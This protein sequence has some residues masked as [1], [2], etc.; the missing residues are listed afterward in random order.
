[1]GK[2]FCVL[3]LLLA[4][5][6]SIYAKQ[7]TASEALQ[8]AQQHVMKS[9]SFRGTTS[10]PAMKLAYTEIDSSSQAKNE[11]FYIYNKSDSSGYVIVSGD[12]RANTI[13]GFA[14]SGNFNYKK[15]SDGLRYWLGRF[16]KQ[17]KRIVNRSASNALKSTS[18]SSQSTA[19]KSS[20]SA[21]NSVVVSPFVTALWDQGSPYNELCPTVRGQY[22]YTGCVATAMAEVMY[23]FQYP[24][25]GTGSNSYT[26]VTHRF[27]LS[28][29]FAKTTFDW[30]DMTASYGS[31]STS[32]QE[33]AV[34]TL[35]YDCGVSCDM[36][37]G[38]D[39]D[40]G[41][42]AYSQDMARAMVK[43]F[44]YNSNLQIYERDFYTY[45]EWLNMVKTEL[46]N[47]RPVLYDGESSEG[48]HQFVCDGYNS[49]DYFHFNWG[50]SGEDNGYFLLTA[51]NPGDPSDYSDGFN[52]YDEI[53]TGL[54]KTTTGSAFYPICS[55]DPPVSSATTVTPRTGTFTVSRNEVCN[56][57]I[58]DFSGNIGIALYTNSSS[59]SLVSLV[60]SKSLSLQSFSN[61]NYSN[62]GYYPTNVSFSNTSIPSSVANGTYRMYFVY[63]P[64]S[65]TG[66]TIMRGKVGNVNY[67]NVTVSSDSVKISTPSDSV[68][69]LVLNSLTVNGTLYQDRSGQFALNIT[70]SGTAEYL[71]KIGVKLTSTT[72]SKTYELMTQDAD[73]VAG[74][75]SIYYI[76]DTITLAPGIYT[77]TAMYDPENNYLSDS[78]LT[79]FGS[80]QTVTVECTLPVTPAVTITASSSSICTG[81]SVTFT[82]SESNGGTS[83]SYQWQV[84]GVDVGSNSNSFTTA[85]LSNNAVVT[86]IL[87][88]NLSCA[89]VSTVTSNSITM[90]VSTPTTPTIAISTETTYICSG[91]SVTFSSATTNGGTSPTFQWQ[92]NSTNESGG[93]STFTTTALKNGDQVDCV[94][95]T[96]TACHNTATSN[97]ITMTVAT[98]SVSI[99][100]PTAVMYAGT[101]TVS[102]DSDYTYSIDGTNYQSSN[103]FSDLPIGTYSVTLKDVYGTVSSATSAVISYSGNSGML[104]YPNPTSGTVYLG[105]PGEETDIVVEIVSLT[106]EIKYMQQFAVDQTSRLVSV[107]CSGMESG[108]YIIK[109]D[110]KK[111]HSRVKL[112]KQ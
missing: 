77:L 49:G 108:L 18:S 38:V 76:N 4:F 13:L 106:G 51:L 87:T 37:Y 99:V 101:I 9:A 88:S 25:T 22:C 35:M 47:A 50:W 97:S 60:S 95:T 21:S 107:N 82:A 55:Y 7:R 94:L 86:C 111:L 2:T 84:N 103:V 78:Q 58:N 63:Q 20:A 8:L 96:N 3:I 52:E 80:S 109:V 5:T 61:T 83:P 64:S 98:P 29:N 71:S 65:A 42:G 91:A 39:A 32:A 36:D 53:V 12:D 67:L 102:P 24:T 104:L 56:Y 105:I 1:M 66:W 74:G 93:S 6:E 59:D 70:N 31:S 48:G 40:D 62:D 81:T 10:T 54:Q 17:M 19:S 85:T 45:S 75:T 46:D 57:G 41:S 27:S 73:F 26:S 30:A 89:I 11:L 72:S 34:A 33:T 100:Q 14:D 28:V 43:N 79:A 90:T 16:S 68:P 110:G 44:S 112:I 92:I 23:Y 69:K 15:M